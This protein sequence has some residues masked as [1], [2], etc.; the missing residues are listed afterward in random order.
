M[1]LHK[2]TPWFIILGILGLAILSPFIYLAYDRWV[3]MPPP[4]TWTSPPFT[5]DY[6]KTPWIL[7]EDGG[8]GYFLDFVATHK[9]NNAFAHYLNAFSMLTIIGDES[10]LTDQ[11][12]NI[13]DK[14]WNQDYPLVEENLKLNEKALEEIHIGAQIKHS[15]LPPT[16][17]YT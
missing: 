8:A 7:N 9:E 13:S 5:P 10:T 17:Y 11:L 1:R 16:P 4:P 3:V 14:G 6:I 12:V 2:F 15:E